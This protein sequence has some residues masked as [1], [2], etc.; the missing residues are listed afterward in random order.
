MIRIQGIPMVDERLQ[1]GEV[2]SGIAMDPR[3]I[4]QG[5]E[6]HASLPPEDGRQVCG[7]RGHSSAIPLRACTFPAALPG[8]LRGTGIHL[9]VA[10]R[11]R[12]SGT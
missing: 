9:G 8:I 7:I 6:Q 1:A 3:H 5:I 4:I 12:D 11:S 2:Q 10:S